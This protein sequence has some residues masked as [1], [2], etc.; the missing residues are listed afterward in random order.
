MCN[1]KTRKQL[2]PNN[3]ADQNAN[4]GFLQKLTQKLYI[5]II[6]SN[7]SRQNQNDKREAKEEA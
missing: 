5:T 2:K 7:T 1:H 3:N 6:G 4:K